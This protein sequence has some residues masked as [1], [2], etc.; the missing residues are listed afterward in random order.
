MRLP[1]RKK[2]SPVFLYETGVSCGTAD[3]SKVWF[4]ICPRGIGNRKS[5]SGGKSIRRQVEDDGKIGVV[6]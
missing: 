1:S 6:K 3:M 2:E 4:Y 5:L